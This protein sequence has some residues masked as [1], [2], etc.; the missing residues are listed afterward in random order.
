MAHATSAIMVVPLLILLFLLGIIILIPCF[1][2]L[3]LRVKL[4]VLQAILLTLFLGLASF[5]IDS[6]FIRNMLYGRFMGPAPFLFIH[7]QDFMGLRS[8]P[9][10]A[11]WCVTSIFPII[12]GIPFWL[13]IA[14]KWL[15]GDLTADEK[16]PGAKGFKTWLQVS[17]LIWALLIAFC[18][19]VAFGLSFWLFLLGQLSLLALYPLIQ[20]LKEPQKGLPLAAKS[21][22]EIANERNRVLK[23]LEERKITAEEA[24]ELMNAQAV[25]VPPPAPRSLPLSTAR[26]TILL[27]AALVLIGFFLPWFHLKITAEATMIHMKAEQTIYGGDVKRGMGWLILFLGLSVAV[28]PY[29]VTRMDRPTTRTLPFLAIGIG[30][31]ILLYLLTS[32]LQFVRAGIILVALGYALE[33]IGLTQERQEILPSPNLNPETLKLL[34]LHKFLCNE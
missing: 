10:K 16:Q 3:H 20:T 13:T 23:M 17:N 8:I 25:T 27:G 2:I 4:P 30:A 14:R 34:V 12:F 22:E 5:F 29:L 19:W 9:L 33:I 11:L 32:N 15:S 31:L 28:L 6:F 21:P 18:V 26:R 1:L 7:D 24:S